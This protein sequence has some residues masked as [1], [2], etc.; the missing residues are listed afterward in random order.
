[1]GVKEAK[2][3]VLNF[4]FTFSIAKNLQQEWERESKRIIFL[5]YINIFL[6]YFGGMTYYLVSDIVNRRN[7]SRNS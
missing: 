1:M 5:F 4:Y 7:I 6:E 3:A 2:L